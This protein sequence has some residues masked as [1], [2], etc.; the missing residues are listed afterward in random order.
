MLISLSET[1]VSVVSR[2]WQT[3]ATMRYSL[4]IIGWRAGD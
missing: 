1:K 3:V 2:V 4:V